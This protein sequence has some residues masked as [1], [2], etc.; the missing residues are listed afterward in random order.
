M[1]IYQY[2]VFYNP[3]AYKDEK[4]TD[5]ALVL[6]EPKSVLAENDQAA[7]LIAARSI[8]ESHIDKLSEVE[9][10]VRPF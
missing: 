10:V 1:K 2:A 5:K 3:K 8:P 4:Q 9:V 6:V 7:L